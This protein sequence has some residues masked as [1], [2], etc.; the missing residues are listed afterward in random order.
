M[1]KFISSKD[2]ETFKMLKSLDTT[3]GR[4][5][6]NHCIIEGEKIIFE[7]LEIVNQVFICEGQQVTPNLSDFKPV[8]LSRKL[9]DQ[10]SCLENSRGI[11]A[12]AELP[13]NLDE[14]QFP[15]LVLDQ[16]QD[17]GNMGTLIRSAVAFGFKTIIAIFCPGIYSQKVIRS[18]MGMQFRVA[19][20]IST[21]IPNFVDAIQNGY[22]KDIP[23]VLA[24]VKGE[25]LDT[26]SIPDDNKYALVLGNEG[27]GISPEIRALPNKKIT[28][29]MQSGVESLNVGVAGGILM[30]E[31]NKR[32]DK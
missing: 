24:D 21:N 16:I 26:I 1:E 20:K 31:L 19:V 18:A 14:L 2:N 4:I 25:R 23:I 29:P 22:L 15:I 12:T 7:N 13:Q 10:V 11:I 32:E 6:Y 28:I 27:N 17:P 8:I 9:F 30:Y 3:K 5:E